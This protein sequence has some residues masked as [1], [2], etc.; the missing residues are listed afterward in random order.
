MD[1][2]PAT[3]TFTV[4]PGTLPIAGQTIAIGGTTYTFESTLQPNS[5]ADTVLIDPAGSVQNTLANLAGAIDLSSSNGQAAGTTYSS[6]TVAANASVTASNPTATSLTLQALTGGTGGDTI[7]AT[8]ASWGASQAVFQVANLSG[9][10]TGVPASATLTVPA[11]ASPLT[12]G[13]TVTIGGTTYTFATAIQGNSPADTVLI[14]P[15][16]N[17]ANTLANLAAAIGLGA[18]SGTTYSSLTVLA[19]ASA[20]VT[21]T[22][23]DS[24]TL[25]AAHS[26]AGGNSTAVSTTWSGALFAGGDLGGRRGRSDRRPGHS[27]GAASA[28]EPGPDRHRRWNNLHLRGSPRGAIA[29]LTPLRSESTSNRPLPT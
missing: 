6:A 8:S 3:A 28:P 23:P 24:I 7:S 17:V 20:T 9:G 21:A 10:G 26:G 27:H 12:G 19:N 5:P 14:D 2:I 16:G 1:A 29:R 11:G 25:T 13:E 15:Q 18:G 22:S 4:P